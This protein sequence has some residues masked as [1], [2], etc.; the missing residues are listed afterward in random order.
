MEVSRD[1]PVPARSGGKIPVRPQLHGERWV[2]GGC[3]PCS[4]V[5]SGGFLSHSRPRVCSWADSS[6]PGME[7]NL[8]KRKETRK[9]LRIKVISM[10]NAEVGKVRSRGSEMGRGLAPMGVTDKRAVQSDALQPFGLEGGS[11]L[12]EKFD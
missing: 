6:L 11:G 9:S 8:P 4:Q 7:A 10:G 1:L 5:Q 3:F 2:R 12:V